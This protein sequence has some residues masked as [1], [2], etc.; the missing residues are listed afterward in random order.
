MGP[1]LTK[2]QFL[3]QSFIL[4]GRFQASR[5]LAVHASMPQFTVGVTRTVLAKEV[6]LTRPF[7]VAGNDEHIS[8]GIGS[9]FCKL[10]LQRDQDEA[11]VSC[12]QARRLTINRF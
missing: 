9:A 1:V 8:A 10:T 4:E 11:D 7:G 12:Q 3:R 2:D 5:A 6:S